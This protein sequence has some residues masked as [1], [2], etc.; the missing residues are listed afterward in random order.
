M[1]AGGAYTDQVVREEGHDGV[2]P[3]PGLLRDAVERRGRRAH[4]LHE[5][6]LDDRRPQGGPARLGRPGPVQRRRRREEGRR[7]RRRQGAGLGDH[8]H[9]LELEPAQAEEPR[10]ARPAGQEGALDVRRP[11][12][13]HRGRLQR[14]RGHGR[15]PRRPHLAAR[16]PESRAARVRLRRRATRCSTSSATRRAPDGIRVAPATTGRVRPAGASDEVRDRHPDLD[17]LQRRPRVR[18]REGGLRAKPAS[19]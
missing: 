5:R 18:D 8:Q 13:D 17:G 15:E 2:H 19:R 7:R 3:E 12:A 9:H 1:V 16:E 6:R 14:L 11:P 4:L 10:A